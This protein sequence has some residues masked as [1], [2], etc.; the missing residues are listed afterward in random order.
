MRKTILQCVVALVSGFLLASLWAPFNQMGN[1]WFALVPLLL[2][3]RQALTLRRAFLLGWLTGFVSWGIQLFWML[4]L[5]ENGGP[6]PLVIPA[7]VGL[8]AVLALYFALFALLC[9]FLR[10]K[11]VQGQGVL[12]IASVVLLEPALWAGIECLRGTLLTGFAWNPLGLATV[13]LLPVSQ[14]AAW[15]GA[16]AVSALV[17]A[18]NGAVTSLVERIW[19]N[20][21]YRA[22]VNWKEKLYLSLECV[23]PFMVLLVLFFAGYTRMEC[24]ASLPKEKEAT[25]IVERTDNPSIFEMKQGM[26]R[27]VWQQGEE[28][29]DLVAFFKAD[30]WVWPESAVVEC[31]FPEQ[32]YQWSLAALA[33]KAEVP[34]FVGGL[35]ATADGGLYNA[36]M[37]FTK[38][39]LDQRQVY[40][41]RHLVPFGEYIPFDKSFPWLQQLVPCGHTCEPGKEVEVVTTPSG[42]RVGPLICFEDTVAAVARASV[43]AGAELLVNMSNDAWYAH[44]SEP[45]QHAQQA[46]LRCIETGVPMVRSTNHG[47]NTVIDAT[48]KSRLIEGF[49]T[50]VSITAKPFGSFYLRYGDAVFGIP[51]LIFVFCLLFYCFMEKW[52]RKT[53]LVL[54]LVLFGCLMTTS[55]QAE[56]SLLPMAEMSLDDNNVTLAERTAQVVLEKVGL[57]SEDRAKA[58]EVLIRTALKQGDWD[59]ALERIETCPELPANRRLAFTL[60][61][62]SGKGL[63]EQAMARY[64]EAQVS[65]EDVWGVT[66]L[67]YGLLAA[68]ETG[69]RAL[70]LKRFAE[71]QQARGASDTIKAENALAWD[72]YES[73]EQSRKALLISA[74]QADRG[75]VF[76]ACALALPN[77]FAVRDA[78]PALDCLD[79]LLTLEGLSTTIEAQLS[80]AAVSLT[81]SSQKKLTYARRAVSVVREERIRQEALHVLGG[82]LCQ[83]PETLAEGVDCL[84][85]AVSLNP[86]SARAPLIQFQIAETLQTA[87]RAEEALKAYNRYMESYDIPELVVKV[88]QGKAR[89]LFSLARYDE[90]LAGFLDAA[91]H[92]QKGEERFGLMVEAVD[93]AVAAERY[94][95]AIELCQFLLREGFRKGIP[96]RLAR[97]LEASGDIAAAKRHYQAIHADETATE[98]EVFIAVMRL[99][100]LLLAEERPTEAIAEYSRLIVEMKQQEFLLKA[101]LERGRTYYLTDNLE[102]AR[103]DFEYLQV[104]DSSVSEESRFFLVLCLYRLGED[105]RARQLAQEYIE[106]YPDSPRI[107]D[108]VLW[109]AKSDFNQGNYTEATHEFFN[110]TTRWPSDERV[111]KALYLSAL[112][113]YQNQNYSITVERVAQL[114]LQ[115]PAAKEIPDA[116]FLQAEALVEQARHAEARDLLEALIRRY[117]NAAW[118]AE[119]YGLLGD[120]LAYTAIDDPKR[121]TLAL[122]AYREAMLRLED[123][124]DISL[125]YQFRI[126][127]VLERQNFRD[128]AAEQYM[129][130]IYRVLNQPE[131]SAV[132]KQWF[133]KALTQLR[134]IEVSRGNL[135]AFETLLWRVRRMKIP[136]IELP[137]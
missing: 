85:Q 136:G 2:L 34:L 70:A 127:R 89:L 81:D 24:Y 7:W 107:P 46:I 22:P 124:L 116:R 4:S 42:L 62:L 10:Q 25:V 111:P 113:A 21:T 30:L 27:S 32:R 45:Q 82:L 68:Q 117:P 35:Y 15:G 105:E 128:D 39:G 20:L 137:L 121:Y 56:E 132:G 17:V 11:V 58:Q 115:H 33:R 69:N 118:I 47:V 90:A 41:K 16:V 44:S 122:D 3:L 112:S 130:L 52:M 133:Q 83:T 73:S 12:R 120:C 95:R 14:L 72:A 53:R 6:W 109:L 66:A 131:I 76:L 78:Q 104:T 57:A 94:S 92:A 60:A 126:G 97:S 59:L 51:C 87:G 49:P 135:S 18:V 79:E 9:A 119:A 86:S 5:T 13:S 96:L 75:G 93:A 54:P 29:A 50:R 43:L 48:G 129:K 100:G 88:R 77:V 125:M 55:A 114:A 110:F 103:E 106:A 108:V 37:L 67:R 28:I 74:A 63:F 36:A 99:C 91:E 61:A 102:Q 80:L 71:V 101:Y 84:K 65:M 64:D 134:A 8:S 19:R 38:D 31:V 1:V 40:G 123:D 26:Y 23:L 98:E